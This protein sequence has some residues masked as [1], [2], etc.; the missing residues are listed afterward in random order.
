MTATLLLSIALLLIFAKILGYIFERLH[1]S[2][3]VGEILAG[4]LLGPILGFVKPDATLQEIAEIGI[5]FFLFLIGLSTKLDEFKQRVYS[6]SVIALAGSVLSFIFGFSLG[7]VIFQKTEIAILLGVA[8]MSTSTAVSIRSVIDS[9]R[10]H[11]PAGKALITVNIADE[12]IA[13]LA[14]ALLGTYSNLGAIRLG[15]VFTLFLAVLG[16]F[17]FILTFGSKVVG[18]ALHFSQKLKDEQILIT[19]AIAVVFIVSFISEH[20]G[21]AAVTGA[22]LAGMAMS[23]SPLTESSIIP[24]AKT[25]GYGFFIPL[26]FAYSS[27]IFNLTAF[28][29]YFWLVLLLLVVGVLGKAIGCGLF[30]GFFGYSKSDRRVLS[31]AMI[32]RGEYSIITAQIVLGASLITNE[33]YTVILG[34][35]LLSIIITPVV[36]GIF[37]R[38]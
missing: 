9:G 21:V 8:L 18:Q 38:R 12:V 2:S 11:T 3:L 37:V 10:F 16:F 17:F 6:S 13:L 4:I 22:F 23:K 33:I 29:S 14:L 30:S 19:T 26:F 5:I 28:I 27:I 34:L 20:V 25:I 24:K 7:L 31:L 36:M 1:L 35:V 15:E 32:P